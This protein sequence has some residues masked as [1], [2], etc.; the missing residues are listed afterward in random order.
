MAPAGGA[1]RTMSSKAAASRRSCARAGTSP[2]RRG[3]PSGCRCRTARS[4]A[5]RWLRCALGEQGVRGRRQQVAPQVVPQ[6]A[7][8]AAVV[9]E[10]QESFQLKVTA[11]VL[12]TMTNTVA[13]TPTCSTPPTGTSPVYLASR[14]GRSCAPR[15]RCVQACADGCGGCFAWC[16]VSG[17]SQQARHSSR[18]AHAHGCGHNFWG[19]NI[20]SRCGR[21]SARACLSAVR[22]HITRSSRPCPSRS[23]SPPPPP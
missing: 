8:Q 12:K 16:A 15:G 9:E 17:P 10:L 18:L 19:H 14:S 4:R 22:D 1:A 23:R 20:T 21:H 2:G 11:R 13:S 5:L 3:S 6:R 7:T